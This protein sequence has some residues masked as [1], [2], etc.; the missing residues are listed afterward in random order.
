MEQKVKNRRA[1]GNQHALHSAATAALTTCV[2]FLCKDLRWTF[3][4]DAV[5]PSVAS[6]ICR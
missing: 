4:S 3:D 2:C 1:I 6:R 5:R